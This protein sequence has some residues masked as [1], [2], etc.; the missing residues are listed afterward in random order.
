MRFSNLL[1]TLTIFLLFWVMVFA[2]NASD[3]SLIVYY[4]FDNIKGEIVTDMSGNS[5]DGTIKGNP[6]IVEGKSGSALE[7]NGNSDYVI[8]GNKDTLDSIAKALTLSAWIKTSNPAKQA[9][10]K[11]NGT[12]GWGPGSISIEVDPQPNA[13]VCIFDLNP[14]Q[15][16]GSTAVVDSK[17]HHVAGTWDGKTF[18]LYIDGTLNATCATGGEVTPS[19]EALCVAVADAP[20]A[21]CIY[22]SGVIDD[23]RVYN[24][25][26]TEPE[27]I[28]VSTIPEFLVEPGDK[29]LFT[30]GEIKA[31]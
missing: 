25:A 18:K 17:W 12:G 20:E 24:R 9:I 13:K 2:A 6:K 5:I 8:A 16:S 1:T 29:L 19:K 27:I 15:C 10:V 7:F 30:W 4:S 26:L 28:E 3:T 23:V 14:Q 21:P 11:K 31:K 22:F